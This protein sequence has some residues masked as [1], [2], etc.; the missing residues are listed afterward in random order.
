MSHFSI[1]INSVLKKK[2]LV[3]TGLLSVVFVGF[4]L[5]SI[6]KDE[7]AV[8]EKAVAPHEEHEEKTAELSDAQLKAAAIST[9]QV[10]PATIHETISLYGTV[11]ANGER[12]QRVTARFPGVIKSVN[13]KLGDSVRKGETLATIEGNE[14]LRTYNVTAAFDGVVAERN[15]NAD[16]H[17]SDKPLLIVADLSSVWVDI[18]IFPRDIA[19]IRNGQ[20]V[21]ITNP[22]NDTKADGNIIAISSLGTAN[23][24]LSA[25]VLLANKD[26]AWIP[27]MFV[28]A[29]VAIAST[30]VKLAIRS[31][32]VQEHEGKPVVFVKTQKGFEPRPIKLG[33]T[34][35]N[36]SEVLAGVTAGE[37]YATKN[38]FIIKAELGKDG[39]EHE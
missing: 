11:E 23:Q 16:E 9:A 6:A 22:S 17:T 34:D 25:R 28:N 14:S 38:S 31:E 19:K 29:D 15:A 8:S 36:I 18:A 37:I 24:T 13:K 26:N 32:A 27:G 33:R 30:S 4:A 2:R 20:S 7:K 39:A 12:I 21:R 10:G 3:I 5:N 1:F 35:G